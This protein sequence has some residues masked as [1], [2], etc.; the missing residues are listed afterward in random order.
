MLSRHDWK[1]Q[2]AKLDNPEVRVI[3]VWRTMEYPKYVDKGWGSETW[4]VNK[5]YCGKILHFF[6]GRRCSWHYHIKKDE[7]FW[8]SSGKLLILYGWSDDINQAE[9]TILY[10][11]AKFEV[12]VGLRH[13]MVGMEESML[14]EFSTHHEDDDSIRVIKGD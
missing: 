13:Q 2:K 12:P 3:F 6:S 4:I 10:P 8:L 1:F 11:G 7:V 9:K 14:I 5:D